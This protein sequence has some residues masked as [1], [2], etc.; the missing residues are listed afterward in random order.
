MV[1]LPAKQSGVDCL[2]MSVAVLAE[3]E[4]REWNSI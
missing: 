1:D 4:T 3:E 2:K